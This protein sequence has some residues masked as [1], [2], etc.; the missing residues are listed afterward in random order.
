MQALKVALHNYLEF[1]TFFYSCGCSALFT[2]LWNF[3]QALRV[4]LPHANLNLPFRR[5]IVNDFLKVF[6]VSFSSFC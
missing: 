6:H 5:C 3:S 4:E 2:A 1:Q